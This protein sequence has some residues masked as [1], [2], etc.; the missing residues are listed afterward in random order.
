LLS[1]ETLN[2]NTTI[3]HTG[4]P[5]WPPFLCPPRCKKQYELWFIWPENLTVSLYLN[6]YTTTPAFG[7]PFFT[8][9]G[10]ISCRVPEERNTNNPRLHSTRFC[11]SGVRLPPDKKACQRHTTIRMLFS[12]LPFFTIEPFH[13]N[14]WEI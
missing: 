13:Q 12:L 5:F 10:I 1:I 11:L 7:H 4:R 6:F 2:T 8:R 9:R 3:A 14:L